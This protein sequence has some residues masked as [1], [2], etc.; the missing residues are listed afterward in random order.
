MY[1]GWGI[2]SAPDMGEN[3]NDMAC[4]QYFHSYYATLSK[5]IRDGGDVRG[6]FAW[7]L[8]N[9]FEL[10]QGLA[11]PHSSSPSLMNL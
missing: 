7:S 6:V 3:M 10:F 1:T 2:R 8:D 5:D 4:V 11:N 9:G